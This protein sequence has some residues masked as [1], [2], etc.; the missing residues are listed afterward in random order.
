[1]HDFSTI[2][3]EADFLE[4]VIGGEKIEPILQEVREAR[5]ERKLSIYEKMVRSTTLPKRDKPHASGGGGAA[6]ARN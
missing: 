5:E 6:A 3:S 2:V 4:G 1:M